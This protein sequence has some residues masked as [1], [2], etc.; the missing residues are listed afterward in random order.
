M[1]INVEVDLTPEE[2]R[3]FMGLPDVGAVHKQLLEQFTQR[4][5]TSPEQRDEFMRTLLTGAMTPWQN[6]FNMVSGGGGKP[7]NPNDKPSDK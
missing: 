2:L 1:K 6:F 3:R 7:L 4:V 5:S